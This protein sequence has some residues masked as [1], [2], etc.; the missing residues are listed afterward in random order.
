MGRGPAMR[1]LYPFIYILH[2]ASHAAITQTVSI[3]DVSSMK[4]CLELFRFFDH[5]RKQLRD[6]KSD[7][8]RESKE[9]IALLVETANR[10]MQTETARDGP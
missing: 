7:A 4:C 5:A 3:A 1:N 8:V 9:T 6:E 2:Q 10:H